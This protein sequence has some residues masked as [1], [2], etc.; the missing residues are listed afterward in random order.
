MNIYIYIYI[1]I[2]IH[3]YIYTS[4]YPAWRV[5]GTWMWRMTR[6]KDEAA[7]AEN[8]VVF[9]MGALPT[10]FAKIRTV[11]RFFKIDCCSEFTEVEVFRM[12]ALPTLS[13]LSRERELFFDNL[14]VRIPMISVDQPCAMRVCIPFSRKPDIYLP[15]PVQVR[16]AQVQ[17]QYT[18]YTR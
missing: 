14:L 10:F 1:Y 11:Q 7:D 6:E 8:S 17:S 5:I 16:E 2:C 3:V 18:L 4:I 9:R 13:A 12:G 15:R